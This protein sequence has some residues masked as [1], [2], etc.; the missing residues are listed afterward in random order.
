MNALIYDIEAPLDGHEMAL[1][2]WQMVITKSFSGKYV[3]AGSS[4]KPQNGRF[5]ENLVSFPKGF[6]SDPWL[7]EDSRVRDC[8]K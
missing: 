8:T 5:V 4:T 3:A 6:L 1:N 2:G 7:V